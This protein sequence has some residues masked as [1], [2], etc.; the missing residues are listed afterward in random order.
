[1]SISSVVFADVASRFATLAE[2]AY[3]LAL[4]SRSAD[5]ASVLR[6]V[7]SNTSLAMASHASMMECFQKLASQYASQVQVSYNGRLAKVR[8]QSSLPGLQDALA[9]RLAH[10]YAAG[11]LSI[12]S[13]PYNKFAAKRRSR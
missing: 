7:S 4:Q 5:V 11:R 8:L 12:Y 2:H 13:D 9:D 6:E 10:N 3:N 1:M